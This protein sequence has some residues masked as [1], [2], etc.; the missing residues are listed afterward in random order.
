MCPVLGFLFLHC[1]A[2]IGM[3]ASVRIRTHPPAGGVEDPRQTEW[4]QGIS[5]NSPAVEGIECGI[6]AR[7]QGT[8]VV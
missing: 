7:E 8:V 1:I 4:V 3:G 2:S 6:V 5:N